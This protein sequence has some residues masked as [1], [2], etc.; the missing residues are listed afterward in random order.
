MKRKILQIVGFLMAVA[1]VITYICYASSLAREHRSQQRVEE[2]NVTMEDIAPTCRFASPESIYDQLQDKGVAIKNEFIEKVDVA[3]ISEIIAKNGYVQDVDVYVTYNGKACIDV[4]QYRPI[5]RLLNSGFNSYVTT[6]GMIFRAPSGSACHASV[7]TGSF[8]PLFPASY[9]GRVDA[10]YAS[11]FAKEDEQLV[12]LNKEFAALRKNRR[13]CIK[14]KGELKKELRRKLFESKES[15]AHRVQGV[16]ADIAKCN[17][18][19]LALN[20]E[21]MQLEKREKSI[22]NRK[23]KLQKSYDDFM[24]LINF[25]SKVRKDDFWGAEVVQYIASATREGEVSLRLI[26]RSGDFVIE[27][28]TLANADDKLA[29]LRLFYDKGLSRMGWGLYKTIDVRYDK[30]VI[31]KK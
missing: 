14:E 5:V 7:V 26:P 13:K 27:F 11:L 31:C 17:E 2:V 9:E 24:N 10:F 16:R 23:K 25:V 28:G 19:M 30:Q 4:T 18:K 12:E 8:K 3:T 29:K 15:Q 21:E 6:D 20:G 22:E 1:F